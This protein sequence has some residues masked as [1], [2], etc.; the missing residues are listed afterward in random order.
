MSYMEQNKFKSNQNMPIRAYIV[1]FV[2]I[3]WESNLNFVQI[4]ENLLILKLEREKFITHLINKNY[5]F[6]ELRG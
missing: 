1:P 5:I 2:G 6:K 4:V 3:I